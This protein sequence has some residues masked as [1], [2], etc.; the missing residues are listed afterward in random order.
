MR[1]VIS[2]HLPSVKHVSK[3]Q[4]VLPP[5]STLGIVKKR[6]RPVKDGREVSVVCI[7]WI[8]WWTDIRLYVDERYAR[9]R[10][11]IIMPSIPISISTASRE[12]F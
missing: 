11:V 2:K 4:S 8:V 12:S 5:P 1:L 9:A 3:Q 6:L 10:V 7:S